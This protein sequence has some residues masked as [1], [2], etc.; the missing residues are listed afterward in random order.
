MSAQGADTA[1][2]AVVVTMQLLHD[3]DVFDF[4]E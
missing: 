1:R 3:D 4:F 2:Q